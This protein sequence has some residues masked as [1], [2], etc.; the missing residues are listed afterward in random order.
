MPARIQHAALLVCNQCGVPK[1]IQC[2]KRKIPPDPGGRQFAIQAKRPP[3]VRRELLK[4]T[5]FR[6]ADGPA[7]RRTQ[8]R[9]VDGDACAFLQ[10]GA[11]RG[12]KSLRTQQPRQ[13]CFR[14]KGIA[15]SRTQSALAAL[16]L[17]GAGCRLIR[18]K[19]RGCGLLCSCF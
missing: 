1:T 17:D 6:T 3:Q 14:P 2:I 7:A 15:Q 8:N 5:V 10:D 13:A 4:E 9:N 12:A 16:P 18:R 11:D 19:R